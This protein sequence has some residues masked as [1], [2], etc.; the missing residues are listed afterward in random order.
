MHPNTPRNLRPKFGIQLFALIVF[1]CLY[2]YV[3]I[4]LWP[5]FRAKAM[6]SQI[7]ELVEAAKADATNYTEINMHFEKAFQIYEKIKTEYKG[8]STAESIFGVRFVSPPS[9]NDGMENSYKE[10]RPFAGYTDTQLNNLSYKAYM[11]SKAEKDLHALH[12]LL[13]D[14]YDNNPARTSLR[15][16]INKQIK[17]GLLKHALM[18]SRQLDDEHMRKGLQVDIAFAYLDKGDLEEA[19]DT[20]VDLDILMDLVR[21]VFWRANRLCEDEISTKKRL[22]DSVAFCL[23]D[24][25]LQY[26][27]EISKLSTCYAAIG[28]FE[29][30]ERYAAMVPERKEAKV[31]L[32]MNYA[33][34]KQ[35][36]KAIDIVRELDEDYTRAIVIEILACNDQIERALELL[37]AS[38]E[39][40]QYLDSI[41]QISLY[42]ARSND[43][44]KAL[45]YAQKLNIAKVRN[46]LVANIGV[47]AIKHGNDKRGLEIIQS[48]HDAE[49]I[50]NSYIEIT[51]LYS[52]NGREVEANELFVAAMKIIEEDIDGILPYYV[53][54][55]A[56][57]LA[58]A[59]LY[60]SALKMSSLSV[61]DEQLSGVSYCAERMIAAGK[62]DGLAEI[63]YDVVAR[64][65]NP[66]NFGTEYVKGSKKWVSDIDLL[67]Y[68]CGLESVV[69]Q[70]SLLHR[71]DLAMRVIELIPFD[72]QE[73]DYYNYLMMIT[74]FLAGKYDKAVEHASKLKETDNIYAESIINTIKDRVDTDN[75][76]SALKI[77][78]VL[79]SNRALLENMGYI[80]NIYDGLKRPCTEAE[81]LILLEIVRREFPISEFW[82][83]LGDKAK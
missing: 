67:C 11:R 51:C 10:P 47:K 78:S 8:T 60:E 83:P 79:R 74:H 49:C 33:R 26:Q 75:F 45:E 34:F 7:S 82:P 5:E 6:L 39:N 81:K 35:Y 27:S 15:K 46:E 53:I 66:S 40:I 13:L 43:I 20:A 71:Y 64:V 62:T 42:Y 57:S 41:K 73:E 38:I 12:E 1:G 31:N 2:A 52:H 54:N 29:E 23:K 58:D 76:V 18:L 48:V 14:K 65:M 37:P 70:I 21:N 16:I 55:N 36:D 28:C 56:K 44:D 72:S 4:F 22:L 59:G 9:G 19:Y 69:Y 80:Q 25:S 68:Y 32:A 17:A 3:A 30:A 77:I 24:T 50:V 61:L 63:L